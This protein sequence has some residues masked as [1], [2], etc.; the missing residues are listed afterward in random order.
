LKGGDE[1]KKVLS[2]KVLEKEASFWEDMKKV[3]E[4]NMIKGCHK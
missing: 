2:K 4:K 1:V 3:L